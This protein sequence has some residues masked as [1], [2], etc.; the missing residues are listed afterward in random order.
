MKLFKI[1]TKAKTQWPLYKR[2]LVK[3]AAHYGAKE[4]G[5][6]VSPIPIHILLKGSQL[7]YGDS[8]D[9]DY[10]IVIR[11]FHNEKW[12]P[13]LFHE[14]EHAR[15]YIYGD[16]S[17]DYETAIWEGKK[18]NRKDLSYSKSPWEVKARK[19]ERKLYKKYTKKLLT[20]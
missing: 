6:D 15:Q 7:D 11:L 13:T 3:A 1:R 9:R 17:I 5:L 8:I 20:L 16:L 4:L 19:I 2:L 18:F 10:K 12:L 14:L